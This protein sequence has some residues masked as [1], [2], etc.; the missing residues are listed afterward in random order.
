[1]HVISHWPLK[2][3]YKISL[4]LIGV[5]CLCLILTP[6]ISEAGRIGANIV[7]RPNV[8]LEI[9]KL[10]YASE[11]LRISL[12]N[13]DEDQIEICLRELMWDVDQARAI[14]I[15]VRDFDR[16]HLLKILDN[17]KGNLELSFSSYG[18]YRK[19]FFVKV[20]NQ[21]ANIVR[22]YQVDSRFSIFYCPKDHATWIQASSKPENPF[23]SAT[24]PKDCGLKVNRQN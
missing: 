7:L 9:N 21:F 1:M 12:L 13:Q 2:L 15:H 16:R 22:I 20:F 5:A 3:I 17:I 4:I 14:S 23:K 8:T 18:G 10:L 19:D 11:N 24:V 6:S